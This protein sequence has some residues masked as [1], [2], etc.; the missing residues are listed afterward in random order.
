MW[1]LAV[2]LAG[3]VIAFGLGS[4][5]RHR[6]DGEAAASCALSPAAYV[7]LF[8]NVPLLVQLFLWFFVLPELLPRAMGMW[9]KRDLP[10]AEFWTAVV[11]LGTYTASRVAEQVRAGIEAI[12]GGQA[13]A[14]LATGLTPGPGLSLRPAAGRLSHHRAGADQRVPQH[15]QELLALRSPSASWRSPAGRVRSPNTPISRSRCSPR[16]RRSTASSRSSSAPRCMSS[17]RRAASPA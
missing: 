12:A 14:A 7:E 8:R 4:L 15:L 2:S 16:R 1:T 11:G 17:R 6:A 9:L 10:H 3:W 5:D 13:N